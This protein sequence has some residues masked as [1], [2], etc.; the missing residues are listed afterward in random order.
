[1]K[2]AVVQM[3][4]GQDKK[5]NIESALRLL[6]EA[7]GQEARF[8][9][10]PE[11]FNYR[12]PL[13]EENSLRSIKESIPGESTEPFLKLSKE[14]R[15]AILVGSVYET[16]RDSGKVYNTSVFV[17]SRGE[18]QAIYRKMHLF[19]AVIGQTKLQESKCFKRGSKPATTQWDD[20]KIGLS[21]CY[22]LRFPELYRAYAKQGVHILTVPSAFTKVTGTAHWEVL[23]RSRA[24]ENLSYVL[25]PNQIG[26]D[27]RGVPS[28]GHSMIIDPWGEI[29][30][31]AS[32]DR[33]EIIYAD[34]DLATIK[35]KRTILPALDKY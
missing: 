18:I 1:M 30:A 15:V 25:A 19:D 14:K 21:I 11:V 23:L 33:E 24:I 27:G 35:E 16:I 12:G 13:G 20:F 17:N 22:D 5:K 31:E 28:Y 3:N 4:S 6:K 26:K 10:L 8:I 34:L 2:A 32:E 29:L 9:L 7:I